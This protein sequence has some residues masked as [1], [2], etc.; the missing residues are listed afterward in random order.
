MYVGVFM[1]LLYNKDV[2]N[3]VIIPWRLT[4]FV[5]RCRCIMKSEHDT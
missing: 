1:I 5:Y 4:S 3:D 2:R